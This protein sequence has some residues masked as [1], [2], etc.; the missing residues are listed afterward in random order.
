[1]PIMPVE[2]LG[3][4]SPRM[5]FCGGVGIPNGK[6]QILRGGEESVSAMWHRE[7]ECST[8]VWMWRTG[9]WVTGLICS[10]H[11]TDR[12]CIGWVHSLPWGLFPNYCGKTC[13]IWTEQSLLLSSL[14][15]C[16]SLLKVQVTWSFNHIRQV[17]PTAQE[18]ASHAGLC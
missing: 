11:C 15:E 9:G 16:E 17:A 10:G 12:T 1:M 13:W 8:A 5:I 14:L 6:G 7:G 18:W 2:M 3:W 4:V